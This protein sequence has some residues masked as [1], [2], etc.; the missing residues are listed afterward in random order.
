MQ[1]YV[2]DLQFQQYNV[3]NFSVIKSMDEKRLYNTE[4]SVGF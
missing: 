1:R 2:I 3:A 4:L